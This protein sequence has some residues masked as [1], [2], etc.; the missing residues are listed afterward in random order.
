VASEGGCNRRL[1]AVAGTVMLVVNSTKS[2]SIGL[3]GAPVAGVHGRLP[4]TKVPGD[5][6]E[7]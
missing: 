1:I 4:K 6:N 2:N 5:G 3:M 7:D